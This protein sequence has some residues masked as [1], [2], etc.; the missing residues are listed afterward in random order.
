MTLT[1]RA[2]IDVK[3]GKVV[4]E[5]FDYNPPAAVSASDITVDFA[6]LKKL[7]NYAKSQGWI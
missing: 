7:I 4:E 2:K 1:F 5:T 3:T 6:D